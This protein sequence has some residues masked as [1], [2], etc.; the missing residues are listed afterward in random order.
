MQ[1]EYVSDGLN[2]LFA[3]ADFIVSRAGS[4]S[5]SEFLALKKPH[6]LI[7]LSARAS[8]GDQILNAA[9]FE[10]Q[11]FSMVLQEEDITPQLLSDKVHELYSKRN[12][13]VDTMKQSGQLDSIS[14]IMELIG[15]AAAE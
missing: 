5:I 2:D 15:D 8:R 6:L 12:D 10:S 13:F 9:S 7:P 4:N 1:F 14:T 3:A 11:G